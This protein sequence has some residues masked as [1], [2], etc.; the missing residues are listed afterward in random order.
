LLAYSNVHYLILL[1][2]VH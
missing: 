2:M 1:S